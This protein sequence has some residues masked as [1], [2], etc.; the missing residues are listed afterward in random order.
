MI[1]GTNKIQIYDTKGATPKQTYMIDAPGSVYKMFPM[2]RKQKIICG[3]T[4]GYIA[5]VDPFTGVLTNKLQLAEAG[6]IYDIASDSLG[7]DYSY[8][9]ACEKGLFVL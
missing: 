7:G 9:M 6:H 2:P 5:L 4:L 3:C 1:G 8:L